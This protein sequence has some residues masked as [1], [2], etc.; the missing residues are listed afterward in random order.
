MSD[1]SPRSK[2]RD[3]T[4]KKIAKDKAATDAKSKQD[5]QGQ[6]EQSGRRPRNSAGA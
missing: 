3:R 5:K 4:Q 6:F 1:R 2:Q